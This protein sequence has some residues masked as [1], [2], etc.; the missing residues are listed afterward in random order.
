MVETGARTRDVLRYLGLGLILAAMSYPLLWMMRIAVMDLSSSL[1]TSGWLEGGFTLA[2]FADL[3]SQGG[4]GRAFA[5]SMLVGLS[6]TLGNIL[7]CF[8][9]GYSLARFRLLSNRL[10]FVS[11]IVVLMIPAHI[12]IIPLYVL[13][14]K[15]RLYDTYWAL[16]LPFLVN[17]IGIF[18]VKQYVES[19]PPSMEEAA[20]IDGASDLRILLTIV[21]PLCR[22]ALAVLAIQ[23]FFTNWN[24]FLFPFI[25]TS[26][27]ELRTLPVALALLQGHQAIDWPH[28]MAGSTIAVLPVLLVFILLQRQIVSGITAGALKQ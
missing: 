27:A 18:L 9:T 28:L 13:M 11:V 3:L 10:M 15:A 17:P 16:I 1:G 2:N 22:P 5:N 8:M 25:L 26:S 21:M 19:I 7:F 14:M 20:R 24:S 6:V 12:V 4:L 23:V